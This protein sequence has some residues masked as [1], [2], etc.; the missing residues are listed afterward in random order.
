M[1]LRAFQVGPTAHVLEQSQLATALWHPLSPS[2]NDLVTVT[3]DACVR[4]WEL[5]SNNRHSF[6][7]PAL[8]VDLKKLSNAT[9]TREDFSASKFGANKAYTLDDVEMQVAA[10]CFGGQGKEDEDGWSSMTLWI[11]MTEG[12]VYALCPFLP[13]H[14]WAPA[15]FLPSLTTSVVAKARIYDQDPTTS[16][17]Q[18]RTADQ[19]CKWLAELDKQDP[20]IVPGD[21][22]AME[23]YT[24]PERPGIVP[25]L[26]GPF[27]ISPEPGFGEITDIHA[28][29]P[30]LDQ[31]AL[32][33][34]D[35]EDLEEYGGSDGLSIGIICVATSA[36]QIHVCLNL[37]GIE[38]EWLPSK[39]SRTRLFDDV[40]HEKELLLWETIDCAAGTGPKSDACVPTF[41]LSHGDRYE[42]FTTQATGVHTLCFR[43]WI[44]GLEDELAAPQHDVEGASFRLNVLLDSSSTA[45]EKVTSQFEDVPQTINAAVTAAA[46][47]N[48]DGYIVLTTVANKPIATVIEPPSSASHPFGPEI[49]ALLEPSDVQARP[50]YQPPDT[51]FQQLKFPAQL[52][53]WRKESDGGARGNIKADIRFSPWTLQKMTEAHRVLS[54]ETY[55]LGLAAADLYRRCQRMVNEMQDQIDSVRML[56]NR[57]DSVTGEDNFSES[58][59]GQPDFVRGG[60]QRIE[61]RVQESRE[62]TDSLQDRVE[63]LRSKM[64]LIGGK[65]LSAKER[66]FGEEVT[67]LWQGIQP[68]STPGEAPTSPARLVRLENSELTTSTVSTFSQ[69]PTTAQDNTIASRYEAVQ[70]LHR[71]LLDQAATLSQK[72]QA[73]AA[74]DQAASNTMSMS[75]LTNDYRSRKMAQVLALLDRETAMIDAV[76]ERLQ[77]LQV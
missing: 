35:E 22:G 62:R 53:A 20:V 45:L 31:G 76:Q 56:S 9:S 36:G 30:Q 51:L 63:K 6:D 68:T 46:P 13:A 23:V 4:L 34:D 18:K 61:T 52:E 67:A 59:A 41:T 49:T 5:D 7:E 10:S 3:R 60:R 19:Q 72:L 42:V 50:T 21:Q 57:V 24:R 48:Q 26:Q 75:S 15:T 12:D 73:S 74:D 66:A 40:A 2:G 37:E 25:K 32:F 69:P 33:G 54:S 55:D 64:R 39:R 8:A 1:K 77:R 14:F 38:A 17:V 44:S 28:I 65:D 70:E 16:E 29:A 27:Q 71:H 47:G 58:V 43:P 11:A